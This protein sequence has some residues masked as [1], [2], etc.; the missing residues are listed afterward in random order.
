MPQRDLASWS[1]LIVCF[2]NNGYPAEALSLF[3]QMQLGDPQ[4]A[5][6][7]DGVMMLSVISAVSSLGALELGIWVHAYIRRA[8]LGLT[9]PLGTALI[10][11]Y[12]R[13]GS[14]D[15]S[16]KVF[17]EMPHRNV[18]TWTSLIT[19]LAVHGRSREALR[20][21]RDMR[22]AGL[23]PDGAAYTGAL[24]ACSHGGLVE[25]GWR[26]FESMRSEYGVYPML[27]HYGCMVDLLGRAGMLLE[28]FKFVEDMPIKPNSVIWRTLLGACVNHNDLVL[29]EKAKER[30]NELDPHHDGDYVLLSNAYGGVGNWGGKAG[31][32]NSMRENRIVKEPGLS[33]VHID[34]V[35]H[36]FVSG[37]NSHPEWEEI[38]KFLVS[39]IDTVKLGG[40]APNTSSVLHDIQEEEKEHSLG[41]H[42]EKLAV[43]FVLLYHRDR[44]AIRVIKNLRICYDC[45]SFM[46]HVSGIFD[47][48][49]IIRDRNR[50][51]HFS[52]GS[53]SCG[54]FW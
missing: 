16:V 8:G 53:C 26:V 51:H 6:S 9:V 38:M 7:T 15:R 21:F 17:E 19:G 30:V 47:K 39:V 40:Y 41:Y 22:E 37:D 27:E 5:E 36:E 42:S 14:I 31:V 24:V 25:D 33:V 11:M 35:V 49:I 52:K 13:C 12:S 43:A 4:V 10:N 29:A 34:Q 28:A 48:D 18:V 32:R 46:K 44:K 1:T 23:R 3:Q 45:H 2:T 54:D 20:A 50:F